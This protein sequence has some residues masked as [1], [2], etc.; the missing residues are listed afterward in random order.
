MSWTD[1]E[2]RD[3]EL[4]DGLLPDGT[5]VCPEIERYVCRVADLLRSRGA[6]ERWRQRC[7]ESF[8]ES[9]QRLE[10]H[11]AWEAE[12]RLYSSCPRPFHCCERQEPPV[13]G[14]VRVHLGLGV[15]C[16]VP[17]E[18][19]DDREPYAGG[20][21]PFSPR[22]V[23][24]LADHYL[25]LR[26]IHDNIH[27]NNWIDPLPLDGDG[28]QIFVIA[29][30]RNAADLVYATH[31]HFRDRLALDECLAR[32]E[33]S[34]EN[35]QLAIVPAMPLSP[36]RHSQ[37]FRSVHWYGTDYSFTDAQAAIVRLLWEAWENGTPDV[38]HRSLLETAKLSSDR[39]PDVFKEKG[40]YHSAW[41]SM[42]Q[43]N[44]GSKGS[45]RLCAPATQLS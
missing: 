18:I 36:T 21:L 15:R 19:G 32:V 45:A 42:I 31:L 10:R 26:L 2:L 35:K 24:T 3:E 34:E 25:V 23:L 20:P 38:G 11:R 7:E 28:W 6:R 33:A 44:V 22:H 1:E 8:R 16:W 5:T 17:P 43:S 14:W 4:R 30:R 41:G 39:L 13:E 29:Q 12:R 27:R 9:R 37:D 40:Q